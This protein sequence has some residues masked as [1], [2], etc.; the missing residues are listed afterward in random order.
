[1]SGFDRI[2][3]R[4]LWK[5]AEGTGLVSFVLVIPFFLVVF[6]AVIEFA[7]AMH[8]WSLATEAAHVGARLAVVNNPVAVSNLAQPVDTALN[9]V[10]YGGKWW[11]SIGTTCSA[12]AGALNTDGTT[13]L[14]P[15]LTVRCI[16]T[17]STAGTC[18]TTTGSGTFQFSSAA[19]N[20]IY[21]QMRGLLPDLQPTQVEISYHANALGFVG[22]PYG[23]PLS[24][25]VRVRC[26]AYDFVVLGG[27]INWNNATNECGSNVRGVVIHD[28]L[29]T[30]TGE[31]FTTN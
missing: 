14:C 18:T 24:V 3:L 6:L 30:L 29:A 28:A 19:F 25:T 21:N 9:R 7:L 11:L 15:A 23:L 1:M 5:D 20:T 27:L 13:A 2:L 22:Q 10:A 4:R 26:R 17:S 8:Q 31:D 16:G 12:P